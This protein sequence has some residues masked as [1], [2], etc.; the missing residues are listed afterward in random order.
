[1]PSRSQIYGKYCTNEILT[2]VE[3]LTLPV[4][5]LD[6]VFDV[7]SKNSTESQTREDR[8]EDVRISVKADAT[9]YRNFREF[10]RSDANTKQLFRMI[11]DTSKS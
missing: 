4:D 11:A 2:F 1:M 6:L 5:R 10:T 9:I 8:G 3:K 7:R